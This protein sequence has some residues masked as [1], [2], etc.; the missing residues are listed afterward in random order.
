MSSAGHPVHDL[1]DKVLL[2]TGASRGVGRAI[3]LRAARDGAKITIVAKTDAAHPKLPGTIHSVAE[4]IVAAGGH[5][6]P[7]ATDIRDPEQIE[8]AVAKTVEAFGGIDVLVNNASAI[9]L[10]G[11]AETPVKRLDLLW[12]VNTRGT[13][14]CSQACLPYLSEASNPHILV[15]SPPLDLDPRWLAPHVAYTISKY[16]VSLVVL[17][18]A[19][20]LRSQGIAVNALWPRT[21]IATAALTML[22]GS[23]RPEQCR[24]PE[25]LADAAH[26]ILTRDSRGCTGNFFIDEDV[27]REEGMTDLTHY[28]VDP[29]QPPA[30]DLFI[31]D[32]GDYWQRAQ[33]PP[34]PRAPVPPPPAPPS[35]EPRRGP[36]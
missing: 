20:E 1:R 12:Q 15:L 26:A 10:A 8:R 3:A 6:L 9:Y 28:S 2:I 17:G 29:D 11:T 14:L 31:G 22:G 36:A 16:G 19:E 18:L 23:I 35:D 27:L 13:F 25:I 5:A 21:L 7:V 24:K 4:E 33:R 32:P 30:P 34:G